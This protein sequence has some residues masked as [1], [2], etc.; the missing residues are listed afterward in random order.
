MMSCLNC[1]NE[2]AGNARFCSVCG[3]SVDLT[4]GGRPRSAAASARS[5]LVANQYVAALRRL[6]WLLL[7][8]MSV[9]AMVA[10]LSVYR[11]DFSSLPPTVTKRAGV[12]YTASSRVLVTS[13]DAPYFRTT[14]TRVS[15][16]E[17][18]TSGPPDLATLISNANLYPILV[19]SDEVQKLREQTY[20]AIPGTVTARAI[21]AV[22]SPGRFELSQV[23]VIEIFATSTTSKAAIKLVETTVSSFVK[24]VERI[25]DDAKLESD[26]RILLSELQRPTSAVRNE[27]SSRSI[28]AL[29]FIAVTAAFVA[30]VIVLDRLFPAGG[31]RAPAPPVAAGAAVGSGSAA[32]FDAATAERQSGWAMQG[33]PATLIEVPAQADEGA[34]SDGSPDEWS[35]P[36]SDAPEAA[37]PGRLGSEHEVQGERPV[38]VQQ[39][40]VRTSRSPRKPKRS[41]SKPGA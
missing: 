25:Q 28:P 10:I 14:P 26:E 1:G 5:P 37:T 36:A 22:A 2:V 20:G 27:D 16:S 23:P 30:L 32:P 21:Y 6:W 18:A 39:Q 41:R 33:E 29:L 8:G 13:S 7:L 19:E 34:I 31:G 24:Y 15:P 4:A 9:A 40:P 12:S 17:V 38:G 3:A 11:L 35:W